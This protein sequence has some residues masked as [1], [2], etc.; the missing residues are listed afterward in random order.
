MRRIEVVKTA[1]SC[2]DDFK[3]LKGITGFV[4]EYANNLSY[5]AIVKIPEIDNIAVARIV[6]HPISE[7]D[8]H[9][10]YRKTIP[11]TFSFMIQ[12]W[13]NISIIFLIIPYLT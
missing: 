5:P 9:N 6:E 7:Y 11:I 2:Y 4:K 13:W 1:N 8:I 10:E 3:L 12:N